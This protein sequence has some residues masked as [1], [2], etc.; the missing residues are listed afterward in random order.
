M[1]RNEDVFPGRA[2]SPR[3]HGGRQQQRGGMAHPAN[4]ASRRERTHRLDSASPASSSRLGSERHPQTASPTSG[5]WSCQANGEYLLAYSDGD[6]KVRNQDS[7]AVCWATRS[8]PGESGPASRK[9]RN[10]RS[11]CYW[12]VCA[13]RP[14]STGS[15]S[16]PAN[17][18]LRPCLRGCSATVSMTASRVRR[19]KGW[20]DHELNRNVHDPRGSR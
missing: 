16:A 18:P 6:V 8:S 13:A 19:N 11:R 4:N 15:W 1:P 14:V 9:C 10:A 3:R 2:S 12:G 20:E 7:P 5:E 17:P